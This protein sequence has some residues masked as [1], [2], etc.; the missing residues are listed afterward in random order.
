MSTFQRYPHALKCRRQNRNEYV[1]KMLSNSVSIYILYCPDLLNVS[2]TGNGT[3]AHM[4]FPLYGM[5]MKDQFKIKL[6]HNLAYSQLNQFAWLN[7][8][9]LKY[10]AY[11]CTT[12]Y[13]TT[14]FYWSFDVIWSNYLGGICLF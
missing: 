4:A 10:P 13:K 2:W 5:S 12:K 1:T 7:L 8:K 14:I 9:Q 6:T 11:F 3:T